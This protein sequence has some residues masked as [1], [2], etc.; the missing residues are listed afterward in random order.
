MLKNM[1][2]PCHQ[3]II[4]NKR[5]FLVY[6]EKKH[7]TVKLFSRNNTLNSKKHLSLLYLLPDISFEV[8]LLHHIAA[9]FQNIALIL[10]NSS[11]T[12]YNPN[13]CPASRKQINNTHLIQ[14]YDS[15]T[16]EEGSYSPQASKQVIQGSATY[17]TI[18]PTYWWPGILAK[19]HFLQTPSHCTLSIYNKHFWDIFSIH[20]WGFVGW[21][22]SP[23]GVDGTSDKN[24]FPQPGATT[25]QVSA[26]SRLILT[27]S[28]CNNLNWLPT[29]SQFVLWLRKGLSHSFEFC[30]ICRNVSYFVTKFI[31][32]S[33][34]YW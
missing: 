26:P 28:K 20:F 12:K 1:T 27:N 16:R 23:N 4:C 5:Q 31:T 10:F 32:F 19:S 34:H 6:E 15:N 14:R 13:H 9:H 18:Q 7:K 2:N 21:L 29:L 11:V 8:F 33:S 22:R 3:W 30:Q 24:P 17:S 25:I